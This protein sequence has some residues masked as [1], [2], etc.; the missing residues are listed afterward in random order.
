MPR[1]MIQLMLLVTLSA[2]SLASAHEFWLLPDRFSAKEDEAMRVWTH[3]GERFNGEVVH[4]NDPYIKRF[5]FVTASGAADVRGMHAKPV[6][7]LRTG[8]AGLGVIVYESEEVMSVLP[9][10]AFEAYLAFEGLHEISRR[11]AELGETDAEGREAYVRCAKALIA[12]GEG[13]DA[14]ASTP[15]GL[16][17]EII[18]ESGVN[19]SASRQIE[20]LVLFEG[21]PAPGL[22]LVAVNQARPGELIELTTDEHGRASLEAPTTG[23]WMLTTLHMVRIDDR[24]DLDWLSYWSSI[25]FEL[26]GEA[27]AE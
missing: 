20:T 6:S 8:E 17:L 27:D 1:S 12:V 4:R 16:D 9:A 10:D 14:M 15:V 13:D 23:V 11:R 21:K 18:L 7:F 5:E 22:R 19:R 26:P 24:P 3:H 2:T 25:T